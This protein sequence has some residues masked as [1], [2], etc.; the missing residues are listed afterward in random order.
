M[1]PGYLSGPPL[2]ELIRHR[3]RLTDM[4]QTTFVLTCLAGT[5]TPRSFER[6]RS[7]QPVRWFTADQVCCALGVH[8]ANVW[9]HEW[10]ALA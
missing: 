1:T 6:W 4:G 2:A 3:A 9:P 8:P 5:T 7:G 10:Y